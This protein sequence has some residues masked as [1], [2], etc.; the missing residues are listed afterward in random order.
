VRALFVGLGSV[1][2]RHLQNLRRLRPDAEIHALRAGAEHG[3]VI[4]DGRCREVDSVAEHYGIGVT[5]DLDVARSLRPDVTW[6][7]N[8]S[9]LHVGTARAF[10]DLG[11]HLFIEKPLSDRLDGLDELEAAV[12]ARGLTTMV[13]YQTRFHPLYRWVR[14]RVHE[15]RDR[16]I[17]AAFEW[18]TYLPAHHPYEDYAEG[19]AAREDL[20]GG[21][22]L[23]LIHE[24]DLITDL[25]GPPHKLLAV[26]GKL[27]DLRMTA[28]DTV[29]STWSYREGGRRFPVQLSLSFAQTR[30][31]RRFRVQFE[32]AT[33][34]VDLGTN[35]GELYGEN[36]ALIERRVEDLDRN[37]LFLAE[38]RHFLDRVEAGEDTWVNLAA[39]RLGLELA[40][41]MKQSLETEEWIPC[42][43]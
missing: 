2:Q 41:G 15:R 5:R 38:M 16:V 37:E 14:E 4:E 42:R 21:V 40:L 32:D 23:C 33:L 20:G 17:A 36:G 35:T 3:R 18:N 11:S 34:L 26:G 12:A 31:V 29:M 8:P 9:S 1:G 13:G 30:E 19:Y 22:I 43:P 28:E 25:F 39:G 7:T 24:I 6:V 27:S 10:A